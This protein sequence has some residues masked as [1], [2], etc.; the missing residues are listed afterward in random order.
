[1][2]GRYSNETEFSHIRLLFQAA[3]HTFR[4]WTPKYNISPS[5]AGGFEQLIVTADRP[6]SRQI[7]L[8]RFWFIP[9][10]WPRPL[11]QLPTTFNARSE[12]LTR[13]RMWQKPFET[14]RCLVPA[15]GWREFL[16][17]SSPKQPYHFRLAASTDEA[18]QAFAF[19]GLH[20]TWTSPDGEAVD[21]FAI[22]TTAPSVAAAPI[23]DRMPLVLPSELYEA[24][25]TEPA[26]RHEVLAHAQAAALDLPLEIFPSDPVANNVHYEGPAAVRRAQPASAPLAPRRA[27]RGAPSAELPA[28]QLSLLDH[29]PGTRRRS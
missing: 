15:T 11:N 20:S 10:T 2:C 8:A 23:H 7:R 14:A 26:A 29:V 1:M 21:S 28:R 12:D 22:L 27:Q 4:P 5:S 24:W 18:P 19:A 13:R 6:G 3:D 17:P 25:L 9:S 16:G